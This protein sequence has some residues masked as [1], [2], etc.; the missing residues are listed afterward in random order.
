MSRSNKDTL[1]ENPA[2]RFFEWNGGN[3]T[4]TY[5]DK[6]TKENIEVE[7]PF[8]FLVLDEVA[9]VGGGVDEGDGYIG[10]W[11]NAIR[12]RN[13]RVTPFVVRSSHKGKSRIEQ[14]G[15]WAD[16]KANLVGAKYIKGLYIGYFEGDELTLGYLK[17]RG[18]ALTPWMDLAHIHKQIDVGAWQILK[19]ST[20]KKKGSN[21]YYEP[22]IEYIP[23]VKDETEEAATALDREVLQPYLTAYFGQQMAQGVETV[24]SDEYSGFEEN[25]DET[26]SE[27]QETASQTEPYDE[28]DTIPF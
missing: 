17:I 5:Y 4:L 3:G 22:I 25:D 13:A 2:K 26:A 10:Y 1:A 16:I 6:E 18:A 9:T 20:T 8:R 12:P 14:T 28:S 15:I 21:T 23:T 24:E 27:S 19:D 11:S 7:R